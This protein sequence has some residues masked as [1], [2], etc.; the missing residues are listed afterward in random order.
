MFKWIFLLVVGSAIIM[1]LIEDNG[2]SDQ[3]ASDN[4]NAT[5]SKKKKISAKPV[6]QV[7]FSK[8]VNKFDKEYDS[9]KSDILKSK[10]REKRKVKFQKFFARGL[11]FEDWHAKIDQNMFKIWVLRLDGSFFDTDIAIY[12]ENNETELV[13]SSFINEFDLGTKVRASGIFTMPN[14]TKIYDYIANGNL[15]ESGSM[16]DPVFF[17]TITKLKLRE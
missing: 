1:P 13:L 7:N 3:N 11:R 5:E 6:R 14:N 17:A 16:G 4:K 2:S 9:K 10:V 12:I 8:I 15:T